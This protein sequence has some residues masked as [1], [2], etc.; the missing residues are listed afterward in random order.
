MNDS[1]DAMD[2]NM[3]DGFLLFTTHPPKE[4]AKDRKSLVKDGV[5]G[6]PSLRGWHRFGSWI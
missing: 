5:G 3:A 2:V 1:D 4:K 6:R